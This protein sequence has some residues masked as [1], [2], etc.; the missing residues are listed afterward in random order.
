M[1]YTMIFV[2]ANVGSKTQPLI[3]EANAIGK[4]MLIEP[5]PHLFATLKFSLS[6]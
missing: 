1:H 3:H 6:T 5:V 2:G 4:V